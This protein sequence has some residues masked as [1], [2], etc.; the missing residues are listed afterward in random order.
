M[1]V[2]V[3]GGGYAGLLTAKQLESTLPTDV[4]L[5]LVDDTG[6]HLVQHELHRAIRKPAFVEAISIPLSDLLDRTTVVTDTVESIDRDA[7]EVDLARD[8]SLSAGDSPPTGG[9]LAADGTLKYDVLAICLGAE[10]AYYGLD[11][12]R[13][14]ATPLKRLEHAATVRREFLDVADSGGG[15]VVVGGAGLSG[16]QTAGEL[17]AFAREAGVAD[18]IRIV[19]LE[20]RGQITPT[21]PDNFRTA[22]RELLLDAGVEIRTATTVAGADSEQIECVDGDPI[23]YDQFVW[24][25]GITGGSALDGERPQVRATLALDDRTFVVGDAARVIDADGEAVPASAQAAVRAADV[26]AENVAEAVAAQRESYRP[27]FEQWRFESPGWLISVGDSAV[28]Q[29]GPEVFTGPTANLIKSSVGITYLAEHGSLRNALAVLRNEVDAE[30]KL[31]AHLPS[32][33]AHLHE[34]G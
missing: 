29:L 14:H 17:A 2:A 18:H 34:C 3:L 1:R 4:E 9:T 33:F 6:E 26:A 23:P 28:A 20:Q 8:D 11:D 27:R 16:V 30:K 19:L 25:G 21:F 22:T 15:T 7:R 12:V 32:E 31:F 24:T 10:T 13:E 5:V